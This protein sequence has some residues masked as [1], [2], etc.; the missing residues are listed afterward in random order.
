MDAAQP[1][2]ALAGELLGITWP[3]QASWTGLEVRCAL[4]DGS[5][6]V[7]DRWVLLGAGR[8]RADCGPLR[9]ELAVGITDERVQL[10]ARVV[11]APGTLA[12][13]EVALVGRVDL[14]G[15]TTPAWVLHGGYQSWDPAD[16]SALRA[17]DAEGQWGSRESWWTIGLADERGAGLAGAAARAQ[18][19]CTRF[20]VKTG[21]LMVSWRQPGVGDQAR[22]LFVG[23]STAEWESDP[24]LLAPGRDVRRRVGELLRIGD[25][26][27]ARSESVPRGWLSWY[28]LGP[29]VHPQDILEHSEL[30]AGEPYGSLGYRVVQLDDGWQEA[31]GDWV[32][33]RKFRSGFRLL[34]EELAGRGQTFGLW[35]APFLVSAASDLSAIAPED[36]FVI[37]PT[38]GKRMID[39]R[40]VVLGPM[41]VL[42]G[43]QPDVQAHLRDTFRRLREEGVRYFKIDFLYAGAY[44]GVAALRAGVAAIR[45]GA[46]D[47][48]LVGSG[49]PLLPVADLVDACR[50][51]PDTATPFY[52]FEGGA[53]RP[54]VFADEVVAVARNAAAQAHWAARF[55]V[56]ADVALVGGNLELEQARQLVTVV[57]LSGGLFFASDDLRQL[58]PER[59]ALLTN[60]EVLGL[61]GGHPAVPDWEQNGT[62]YPATHWRRDDV[63]AVFNWTSA[64]EEVRVRAPGA[65]GARDLWERRDLPAFRDGAVL[66]VPSQGVRLLRVRTG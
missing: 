8:Y 16:K 29:W 1:S 22:P 45:D 21:E 23:G 58:A 33:N 56:D 62:G 19:C 63:L 36:W 39:P 64:G 18:V 13:R 44:P 3:K 25:G 9:T 53:A 28:H 20:A 11:A 47:A 34:A 46:R 40:Q 51:G 31:W 61:V 43:S 24:L 17:A 48:Y 41:Y 49:A 54:T 38:T 60:P 12:V 30:L 6:H 14:A 55:Q 5:H 66:S 15:G 35:T 50:I 65:R 37:D 7:G 4:G 10:C 27:R 26:D 59:R 2:A 32:P 57:A 52:D 42:D